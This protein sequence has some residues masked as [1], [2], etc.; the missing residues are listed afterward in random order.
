MGAELTEEEKVQVFDVD[1][2]ILYYEFEA[3]MD[4]RLAEEAPELKSKPEFEGF[5]ET[6]ERFLGVFGEL[7]KM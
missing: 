3:L 7:G 1:D 6:E 2:A 5:E 4:T